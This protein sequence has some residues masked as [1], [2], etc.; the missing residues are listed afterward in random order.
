MIVDFREPVASARRDDDDVAGLDLMRDT[1]ANVGTVVPR[2]VE[3]DDG[4]L[5]RGTPLP[6]DDVRTKDER[7][8]SVTDRNLFI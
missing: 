3:L 6:V 7:R 2:P 1:V 4:A 5:R 8:G